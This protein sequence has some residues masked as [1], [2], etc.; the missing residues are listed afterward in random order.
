MPFVVAT[1]AKEGCSTAIKEWYDISIED[2][3]V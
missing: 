3:S 2:I 1:I